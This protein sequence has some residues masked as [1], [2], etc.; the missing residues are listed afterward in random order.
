MNLYT[1]VGKKLGRWFT[2]GFLLAAAV[3]AGA[4]ERKVSIEAPAQIGANSDL[5]VM[6]SASTD[7]GAG[8][9]IGFF[10]IDASLDGGK[11]WAGVAYLQNL[12]STEMRAITI[13]SGAAGTSVKIRVR[14]AFRDGVAKDVDYT[15]AAIRWTDSWEHWAEPPAKSVTIKVTGS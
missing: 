10:Q 6:I 13:K 1:S 5:S 7:A 4:V 11:K 3:I 2:V 12:N 14:V 15:G 9:H 8:E